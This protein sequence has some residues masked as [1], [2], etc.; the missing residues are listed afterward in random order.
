VAKVTLFACVQ[1]ALARTYKLLLD[2]I[3][4]N[5]SVTSIEDLMEEAVVQSLEQSE[6]HILLYGNKASSWPGHPLLKKCCRTANVVAIN[7]TV[8]AT[9]RMGDDEISQGETSQETA[10]SSIFNLLGDY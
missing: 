9:S 5:Q 1:N 8:E 2:C 7:S 10:Q 4:A 3:K 6:A